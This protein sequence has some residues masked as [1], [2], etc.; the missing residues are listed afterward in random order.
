MRR[1]QSKQSI[2]P[3]VSSAAPAVV[4][5]EQCPAKT[6]QSADGSIRF[7]RSVLEHG[8]IVGEVVRALLARYPLAMRRRL[9]PDQAALVAACHDVG[10]ISPCFFEKL[11]RAISDTSYDHFKQALHPELE[12]MWGGHAGVSQIT[13]AALQA[14]RWIPEILGQH[15]GFSPP[16]ES[17]QASDEVFGGTAWQ[18]ERCKLVEALKLHFGMDWPDV[19]CVAQARLLA[20]LTSVADWIGSGALFE[21]PHCPWRPLIEQALDKAG[22]ISPQYR[23][24][25]RFEE[26]FAF[27]QQVGVVQQRL[28]D[29]VNGPGV[30]VLEAPM[31][32]GKT[33]AALYVAYKLLQQGLATGIYFALPTQLTS[34]KMHERLQEF[35]DAILAPNTFSQALLL[36]GRAW[37]L[38]TEMGEE[39]GP[40]GAWFHQA[41]RG[42]LA[43]FAVGTIDQALMAAMHVKHGFVRAF[44]LAGKVVILDEVHT[45]DAYT[46]TLMEALVSL[47]R[48][49]QCTVIILSATLSRD[50]RQAL[51]QADV[52]QQAYPLITAVA[53]QQAV[54]E[55]TVDPPQESEV[56]LQFVQANEQAV[57]E[58]LNRAAG[59]QQVLWIENTVQ[60]AQQR[61]LDVAA[62]AREMG[63]DCGLL[64]SRF[65]V[66]DRQRIEEKWVNAFGKKGWGMRT[67]QGRILVGTQVLEQSLD[68]DADFLI[69]RFAPSD[70]LLQRMGRLWRHDKAPRAP[71]AKRE[72]CLLVP[73][74]EM[75]VH[76]PEA[77]LGPT[78]SVYSPYVLCRSLEVW[79][80]RT[81]IRLPS[82]IRGVIE[83]S[84]AT[85]PESGPMARWLHELQEGH[86]GRKGENSLR[87][88]ARVS[89]AETGVT[90]PESKAQTRYSES[91]NHEVLLLRRVQT[92]NDQTTRLLLLNGQTL[93]VPVQRFALSKVE[94]KKL[95]VQLM[96]QIVPVRAAH[97]PLPCSRDRL[98][99]LGFQHCLYLGD[100]N[101]A[102]D[103]SVLRVGLVD[104]AGSIYGLDGA[105]THASRHLE[106]R[107]DLGYVVRKN[108]GEKR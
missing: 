18:Q 99:K 7:G 96:S 98:E 10:K 2:P 1:S 74:E 100:K 3:S 11:R 81:H 70:M 73:D 106:Y 91:E 36:H 27:A 86:R 77:A 69:S 82:D 57:Q 32:L 28:I 97:A 12:R 76:S 59:G 55:L 6:Y 46:S 107:D 88:L 103:E 64:H 33:E 108:N 89:L 84:Y 48:Q 102:D 58:A 52:R 5:Y 85:R 25:L 31:G 65:T 87:Q 92:I 39:G 34:N 72:A 40:G 80:A 51:V 22:F 101:W 17:F 66:E 43:P 95:A 29:A 13:A 56:A 16:V 104:E 79:R 83:A 37:L 78:A 93:D 63:L 26:V 47:L 60:E 62:R 14:P 75:A 41:K 23:P 68:I 94:W 49:L 21:D 71:T 54:Q 44:G 35:L 4:P 67:D 30:Y 42:L 24:G 15:H 90:L 20:G 38:E 105:V 19:S 50:R 45:Y 9:F 8:Q 61:Y 53:E